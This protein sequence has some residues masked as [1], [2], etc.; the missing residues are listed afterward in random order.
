MA[1]VENVQRLDIWTEFLRRRIVVFAPHPDD[2]VIG[3]F[4]ILSRYP[5]DRFLIFVTDGAPVKLGANRAQLQQR[6][7]KEADRVADFLGLAPGHTFRLNVPDQETAFQLPLLI[8]R[9]LRLL[10]ELA[11]EVVVLPAYE[12]GHPDHDSTA[13]VVHQAAEMLGESAP[14]LVEM[15]LYHGRNGAMETGAF[16][17][18]LVES[19]T[20]TITFSLQERRLKRNAFGIYQSQR[21]V[22][23]YF[24]INW[25]RFREAPAYNVRYP[26]HPGKLFYEGFDWKVT[27]ARWR[28]L[29]QEVL[30]ESQ[31]YPMT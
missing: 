31:I 11:A 27:G 5:A 13:F 2:E 24:P 14:Q 6:R 18:H 9:T 3:A 1:T 4:S 10:K 7:Q 28:E 8:H 25:E 12:G 22:L 30:S 16:L 19:T 17:D 26:P 29:A 21:E 15:C 23:K 20:L